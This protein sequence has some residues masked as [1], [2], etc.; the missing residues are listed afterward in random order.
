MPCC[1][2]MLTFTETEAYSHKILN[3][4]QHAR[5]CGFVRQP[6]GTRIWGRRGGQFL[7]G[8]LREGPRLELTQRGYEDVRQHTL[9][10]SHP[11]HEI[12][13]YEEDNRP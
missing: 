3:A 2:C 13:R 4:D 8:L 7:V 12:R 6:G 10:Q 1:G 11:E 5:W 9:L